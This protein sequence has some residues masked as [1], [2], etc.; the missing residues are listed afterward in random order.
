MSFALR[1]R[2]TVVWAALM[3]ATVVS[4]ALGSHGAEDGAIELGAAVALF[5]AFV[6][7]RYVGLEFMEL[8]EADPV[9][10]RCFTSWVLIV[11]TTVLVLHL[12]A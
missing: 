12:A 7:V 2:T 11:G 8:R 10:R 6:K 9:L 3:A 5:I 1:D 4:W